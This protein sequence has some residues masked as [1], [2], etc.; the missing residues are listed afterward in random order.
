MD[1]GCVF[2]GISVRLDGLLLEELSEE[3]DLVGDSMGCT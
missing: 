3:Q 1:G 2:G